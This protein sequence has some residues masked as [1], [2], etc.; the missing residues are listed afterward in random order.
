MNLILLYKSDFVEGERRVHIRGDRH[1]HILNVNKS[2]VGAE[3]RVGLLGG[4]IGRGRIT[5]IDGDMVEMEV[6]LNQNPPAPLSVTLLLA[7]MRPRVLKRVL[8]QVSALGVKRIVLINSY[9]VEKSFWKS[10]ILKRDNLNRYLIAGLAQGQD[11]IV[12]K[13]SIRPL[14]KPFV[15]DEL[16]CIIKGT[17]PFVAHPYASKRCPYNIGAPITLAVG[18]EGGFI[19]Y[20]VNKLVECGFAAVHLGERTLTVE[21]AISGLVSRLS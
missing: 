9:R 6:V 3:L 10:P 7:M 19:A 15:E 4:N 13:V 11:T 2:S 8:V 16:P 14:F 21:S 17:H 12:P 1:K 18:P 20:E 5:S